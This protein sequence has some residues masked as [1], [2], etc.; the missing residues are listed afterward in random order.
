[1]KYREDFVTNSSSSSFIAVCKTER[2]NKI[3]NYPREEFVIGNRGTLEFNRGSWEDH[4]DMYSKINFLAIQCIYGE[5]HKWKDTLNAVLKEEFNCDTINWDKINED[6]EYDDAYIDHDSV[7]CRGSRDAKIL[8]DKELCR[9]FIF[10]DKSVLYFGSDEIDPNHRQCV[11]MKDLSE[12][13]NFAIYG[14]YYYV[15]D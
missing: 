6:V 2:E 14:G 12:N 4:S 1:M 5:I 11:L 10:N 8:K 15:E 3:L 9:Q 7:F 13:R